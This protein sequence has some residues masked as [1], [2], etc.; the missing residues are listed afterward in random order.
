MMTTALREATPH[1][2]TVDGDAFPVRVRYEMG[3]DEADD[4]RELNSRVRQTVEDLGVK[5]SVSTLEFEYVEYT[6]YRD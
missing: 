2:F 6:F 3:A 5:S 1:D 4:L